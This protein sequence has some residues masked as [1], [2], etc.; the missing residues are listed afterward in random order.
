MIVIKVGGS[1]FDSPE[2]GP[3]LRAWLRPF[4]GSPVTLVAGGGHSAE[5][6]RTYDRVHALGEKTAHRLAVKSLAVTAELLRTLVGDGPGVTVLDAVT[7]CEADD[8]LP[9]TW[10]VT[11]DSIAARAAEVFGAAKL[12]LLKSVDRPAG[13]SWPEAVKA[14]IVDE[15]FPIA[16]GRLTCPVEVIN[17]RT[18]LTPE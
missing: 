15:Y 10:A 18:R 9:H 17:F 5:A 7:F 14:E 16:V 6:V 3:G 1:L 4:D 12:V 2:L 13:L 8:V 11:T